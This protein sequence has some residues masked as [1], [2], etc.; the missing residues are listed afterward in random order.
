MSF[1]SEFKAF[2][3]K[4]NALDLAI[5]VVIGTSFQAIV[6]AVVNNL[7]MPPIKALSGTLPGETWTLTL[8]EMTFGIGLVI[9]AV[10]QFLLVAVA[11]FFLLKGLNA[12]HIQ[13]DEKKQEPMKSADTA[14][15]EE[16]RDLLR[17]TK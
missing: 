3:L 10:I 17:Q 1:L 6:H 9:N 13:E 14:L 4:R 2:A 12:L 8:G 7:F 11:I 15:L 16:I 5:G